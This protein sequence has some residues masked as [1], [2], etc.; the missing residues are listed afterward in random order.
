MRRTDGGIEPGACAQIAMEGEQ[1]S[2]VQQLFWDAGVLVTGGTGFLGQLLI[3]KILRS[4]LGVKTLF[5]L[6]RSKKG[7][8]EAKRFAEIFEVKVRCWE[9]AQ[10]NGGSSGQSFCDVQIFWLKELKISPTQE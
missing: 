4:C 10:Q 8:S 1:E 6:V 5:L 7:K 9:S 3:E 2:P